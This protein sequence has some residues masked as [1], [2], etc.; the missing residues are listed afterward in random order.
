MNASPLFLRWHVLGA[1][2]L[3]RRPVTSPFGQQETTGARH[4][5][6]KRF[7]VRPTLSPAASPENRNIAKYDPPPAQIKQEYIKLFICVCL[8]C[9]R[10]RRNKNTI[11][12]RLFGSEK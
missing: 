2:Q 11:Y 12:G 7:V 4:D 6:N 3:V 1:L 8:Y 5:K 10:E 9:Q